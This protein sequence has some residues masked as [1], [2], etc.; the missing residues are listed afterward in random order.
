MP[1]QRAR[2]GRDR[3]LEHTV[4]LLSPPGCTVH[5]TL[6]CTTPA[7][8][9]QRP[10]GA[11]PDLPYQRLALARML[12]SLQL[13]DPRIGES[14]CAG[15]ASSRGSPQ[16]G[17]RACRTDF[18]AAARGHGVLPRH[19]RTLL[20]R[21]CTRP[22]AD[23]QSARSDGEKWPRADPETY[24]SARPPSPGSIRNVGATSATPS[25]SDNS[26]YLAPRSSQKPAAST[27][28]CS[29]HWAHGSVL[30]GVGITLPLPSLTV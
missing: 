3:D 25:G 17:L 11:N 30:G 7:D 27:Q 9:F 16:A 29:L 14:R 4:A 24:H 22:I 13:G 18:C 21:C 1:C 20:L 28:L 5:S 26:G 23:Q 15:N 12:L 19:R 10:L 6:K 2:L 8:D